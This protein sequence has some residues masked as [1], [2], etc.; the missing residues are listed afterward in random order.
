MK[1]LIAATLTATA[2][3]TSLPATA[4]SSFAPGVDR[5][6]CALRI[7]TSSSNWLI[8]GYDPFGSNTPAALFEVT[9]AND[10]RAACVFDPVFVLD[11]EPFGLTTQGR[12]KR[13]NYTLLDQ[14]AGSNATPTS[15]RTIQRATNRAV[16]V[17]PGSQQLV[18]YQVAIAEDALDA[19]GLYTQRL[20][21]VAE[22]RSRNERLASR[23]VVLGI[24]VLPSAVLGLSGSY[25]RSGGQALVNLGELA[26]GLAPVPLQ[27]NVASTRAYRLEFASKN[28]GLLKMANADWSV[29]YQLVVGNSTLPLASTASY[30]SSGTDPTKDALP[31]RFMI[32]EVAGKRAGTYS[33]LITV[34]IAPR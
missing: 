34:S 1:T 20:M 6:G 4:Q 21:L 13:I 2:L 3:G 11:Q 28:A 18:R 29:P 12:A 23:Q 32:G 5:A 25:R 14:F 30:A 15:G 10:G 24:E 26:P 17:Q 22:G 19:D 16:V 8:R 9:F 7:D 33:D 27:L 31:L